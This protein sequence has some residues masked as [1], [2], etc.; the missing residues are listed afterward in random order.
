MVVLRSAVAAQKSKALQR[1][2]QTQNLSGPEARALVRIAV[3]TDADALLN[4]ARNAGHRSPVVQAAALRRLAEVSPSHAPGTVAHACWAMV[5][6]VEALRK[7]KGRTVWRMHRMRPKIEKDGEVG[8]LA[9]CAL[10]HTDGFDEVMAHGL[11]DLAA[12]A[13]VLRSPGSFEPP[14]LAAARARLEQAGLEV[15]NDGTIRWPEPQP[16]TS[17]ESFPIPRARQTG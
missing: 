12:E 17:T 11:P 9:Y 6:A 7:L 8:A 10:N 1:K 2:P 3:E 13:I 14:V 4:L 16:G 5:H 15:E